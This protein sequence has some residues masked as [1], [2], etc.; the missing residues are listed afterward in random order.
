MTTLQAKW[1]EN[2]FL[3][4]VLLFAAHADIVFKTEEKKHIKSI[5]EPEIYTKVLSEFSKDNGYAQV[6]KILSYQK[7]NAAFSIE[8]IL[9]EMKDLFNSDQHFH[10]MGRFT[11]ANIRRLLF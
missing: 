3:A 1:T 4:Y 7:E 10:P 11:L 9:Q 6:Q 5:I 8:F 2:E